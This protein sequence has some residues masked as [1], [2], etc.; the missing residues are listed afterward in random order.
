VRGEEAAEPAALTDGLVG[1][2]I[3]SALSVQASS[4]GY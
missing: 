3:A 1:W 4:E 2:Y